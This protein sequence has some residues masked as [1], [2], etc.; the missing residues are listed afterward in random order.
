MMSVLCLRAGVCAKGG[1]GG[2]AGLTAPMIGILAAV[3]IVFLAAAIGLTVWC[4]RK[5][6]CATN[7][8]APLNHTP[9]DVSI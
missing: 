1:G 5:R 2:G 7:G 8:P 4:H 6:C 3:L 9:P